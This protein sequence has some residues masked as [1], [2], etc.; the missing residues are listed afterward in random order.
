ML[1]LSCFVGG[2]PICKIDCL[3]IILIVA[4]AITSSE[5]VCFY[6]TPHYLIALLCYY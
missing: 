1:G 5:H 6:A 4:Y 2:R 3:C